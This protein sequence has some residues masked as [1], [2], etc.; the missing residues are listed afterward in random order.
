[1]WI[2]GASV[3]VLAVMFGSFTSIEPGQVAV[4]VNN[5]TGGQLTI[6]QPGL[7]TRL[8]FGIHTVYVLDASPQTFSMHGDKQTDDLNV[9]ELTVRASDGSNFHFQDTTIIFQI[10]RRRGRQGDPR[11][12]R[13]EGLPQVDAA[14]RAGDPARRVRQ[15]VDDLGLE[16][17]QVRRG[18][19]AGQDP[20][21]RDCSGPT[22]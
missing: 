18:D 10:D 19:R 8:P 9:G 5:V 6:T 21:Q 2:G 15:G 3:A 11:R 13:G 16:P 22:A 7:V 4:R 17:G 12:R 14:L 20:A 1:V